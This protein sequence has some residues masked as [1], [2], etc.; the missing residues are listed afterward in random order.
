MDVMTNISLKQYTTMKLGGETRYMATADSASDVVSLYR[1]AR[2]ENLPIFVLGGG[3]N[4]ITHDEVFEGIVLLNKIK[5]FEVISETDETTDVKIGAGEV[6]DEVVEKAIELGLQGV[7]AMS[8]IPGTA[9]AAP[10]QNVG[11]YGQEIADTLISLE[12]Y[13]SKTDT[14]VTIS[15]DE[16]DFSYRNSIF[17]DKEK[18]RY[19]ILNITLRLN[20]AEPKPPYY[21]SLQKYI[22]ENDI[23]EV[24]LSVI[25]VAVLN[26]RSEKLPDP[27]ELPSAGSFF[28][29]ALVEKWKLEELQKEYSDIPNYAMSDGRYKIPTG[30]LIDKAG[31][32][33]YRSHGMRVYEKNALVL[34]NDSATGYDDLAAIREEIVQ[35]VFDKFGIKIEQEPLELSQQ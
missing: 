25:R 20:K 12:A 1:N 5:G 35:I 10:V 11:A 30:W 23:R 7:E 28:K 21:A 24:N 19:C 27:A 13:D 33:G 9:G 15:A 6:W 22:D 34:V 31:L 2:K 18:G 3:S 26:I 17:R 4:V 29:N 32:R 8:G 16:C 14:I